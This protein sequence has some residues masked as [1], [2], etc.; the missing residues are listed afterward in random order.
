MKNLF[1]LLS[2]L[3]KGL[4]SK[5]FLTYGTTLLIAGAFYLLFMYVVQYFPEYSFLT[6][7]IS[8]ALIGVVTL[9]LIDEFLLYEVETMKILKENAIGYSLYMLGYALIIALALSGA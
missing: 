7:A 9:K 8:K 4:K 2:K 5:L 3:W 1:N 6:Y